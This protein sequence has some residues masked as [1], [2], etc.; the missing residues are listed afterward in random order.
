MI[1]RRRGDAE[2]LNEVSGVVVDTALAIHRELGPGLLE[3]VYEVVLANELRQRGLFVERQ[4][5]VP[6]RYKESV[7]EEGFRADLIVN[8]ELCIELK[9]VEIL[10][11]VHSKQLL[12]YLK[13]MNLEVGLLINFGASTLKEGLHRIVNNYVG[14]KPNSA[15]SPRLRASA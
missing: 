9:S 8:D 6:I 2:S 1:T 11:P 5:M 15:S 14:S 3:T 12:A 13:L 7:F 10:M 4:V